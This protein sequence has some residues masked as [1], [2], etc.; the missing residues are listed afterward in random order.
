MA[1]GDNLISRAD[2]NER[3]TYLGPVP[4]LVYMPNTRVWLNLDQIVSFAYPVQGAKR[5][6]VHLSDHRA[7]TLAHEDAAWLHDFLTNWHKPPML[8]YIKP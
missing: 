2:I 7:I 6:E 5:P 3:V 1:G 8:Q 4:K